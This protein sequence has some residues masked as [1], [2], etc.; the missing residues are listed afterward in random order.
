MVAFCD[1]D[2]QRIDGA[3]KRFP[4]AKSYTDFRKLLEEN[5]DNI[6][7]VTVSTPD[8]THA[9][10]A[11][12]AMRMGKHVYCQKPMTHA[13]YEARLMG[14]V[15]KEQGVATQ[16]GNQ[17]SSHD[18]LRKAAAI[19]KAGKLGKPL[20]A[21]V[22]TNR[23]VWPQGG[24]AP[25]PTKCPEHVKWDLWLSVAKDRPY[26]NGYHP[27]SWR[28]FWDFGTGALGDM[29]CH[30]M[31]M[32]FAA[33][34]LTNAIAVTGKSSGHNKVTYP[35][36]S[37]IQFDF[38]ELGDRPPISLTWY[39][40]GRLPRLYTK[41]WNALSSMWEADKN[42]DAIMELFGR[43]LSK[44]KQLEG[45][46]KAFEGKNPKRPSSGCM[47]I[48]EKG[49]VFS[50]QDYGSEFL[51]VDNVKKDSLDILPVPD[52]DFVKAPGTQDVD[53]ANIRHV[54]EWVNAIRTG[55]QTFSNFT[56]HA[57]PLTEMVLLGNLGIWCDGKKVEWD[58]KNLKSTN[59]EGLEEMVKPVYRKGYVLDV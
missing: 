42:R 30:T 27:F 12:M 51:I 6:D 7:I 39:D 16:M 15:A 52:A 11:L 20:A 46:K 54:A 50:P 58:H 5:E 19:I 56:N 57:G 23:P 26:A 14:Q 2:T 33:L 53:E 36:S 3:K 37:Q 45:A 41:T 31:N 22:W 17:G 13:I 48:C 18:G 10:A 55:S 32:P 49:T 1:I 35:S 43:A 21:H 40:G 25:E 4:D 59:V 29:A 24:P 8:H 9:P 47:V 28:G 44:E 34:N 38:A